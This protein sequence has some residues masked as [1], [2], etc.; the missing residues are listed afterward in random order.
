[1][2]TSPALT[3]EESRGTLVYL[4]GVAPGDAPDPAA[5]LRGVDGGAVRL[6]RA[7]ALAG[8]V[9]DVPSSEYAEDRLNERLRDLDWVGERGVA[10][11]RVLTWYADR[12]P[13]VP[14]SLF[15]LHTDDAR[16]RERM[17]ERA[18]PLAAT[19]Q[20]VAGRREWGIKVWRDDARLRAQLETQSDALRALT[21]EIRA[22][23]EG[24][25]Y[26]LARKRDTLERE[27]MRRISAAAAR[28]ALDVIGAAAE[29]T[30][31]IPIPPGASGTA[32]RTLVLHAAFLVPQQDYTRFESAVRTLGAAQAERGFDWEFTGPWPPY[33]FTTS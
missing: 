26:L 27:E 15:S 6:V 12:G 14:L 28:E 5:D 29:Q 31:T 7:G 22:A 19:L 4:Y 13:V 23:S 33:H 17:A 18:G 16:V 10:H 20:R 8:I 2:N 1:M 32:A 9:G 11:E 3:T 30:A 24:R 25:R 21:A